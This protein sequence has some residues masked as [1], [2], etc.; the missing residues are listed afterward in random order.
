MGEARRR[1][2]FEERKAQAIEAGRVKGV[3]TV[4]QKVSNAIDGIASLLTLQALIGLLGSGAR[5]VTKHNR[6]RS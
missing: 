3:R 6:K 5:G 2:S 1:G 4:K